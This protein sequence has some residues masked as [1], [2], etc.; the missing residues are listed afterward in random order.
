MLF[1]AHSSLPY[2][3][4]PWDRAGI[5]SDA[6]GGTTGLMFSKLSD[7][8]PGLTVYHYDGG[9]PLWKQVTVPCPINGWHLAQ[10]RWTGSYLQLRVDNAPWSQVVGEWP[11]VFASYA[12]RIGQNWNA[13]KGFDG[14]VAELI[15]ANVGLSTEQ[16]DLVRNELS[17]RYGLSL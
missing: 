16:L 6:N 11:T 7:G 3:A 2:S 9:T 8:Q 10:A 14:D 15:T 17:A 5:V 13:T 12:M 1:N 4:N